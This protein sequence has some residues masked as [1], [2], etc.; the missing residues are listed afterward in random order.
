MI[1]CRMGPTHLP[2]DAIRINDE[3]SSQRNA[4]LFNQNAI[5]LAQ[6]VVLIAQEGDVDLAE[7][8]IALAGVGPREE[9]VLRVGGGE[10]D[11]GAAVGEVLGAVAEGDDLGRAHE[12]PGHGHEAQDEPL[13][14]G[15]VLCE[16]A[17]CLGEVSLEADGGGVGDAWLEGGWGLMQGRLRCVALRF[18]LPS[19]VPSTT[20]V[21]VKL[22]AG[23]WTRALGVYAVNAMAIGFVMGKRSRI[24][25]RIRRGE[26]K[27][28]ICTID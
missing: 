26:T 23:R 25:R 24:G 16:A 13:L 14:V 19:K 27:V 6:L 20:A 15:G 21:P 8:A 17:V 1:V 11:L 3:K 10:D 2:Y 7:A 22:G 5:V 28:R 18:D 12:R 4:L 9:G